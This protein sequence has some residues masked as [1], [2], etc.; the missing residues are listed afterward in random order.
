[1]ELVNVGIGLIF[2]MTLAFLLLVFILRKFAWKP[3][4]GA[5][6]EREDSIESALH[7]AD[8]AREEMAQLQA[9]N[10]QLLREA[11]EER[12]AMLKETRQLRDNIIEEAKQKANAEYNRILDSARENIQFEKMAAITELK[13]EVASLSLQF[14]EKLLREELSDKVKHEE[15]IRKHINEIKFN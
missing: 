2:W 5:L 1:M 13:N 3:I 8:K 11:R 6:K 14:A 12:D 4:M 10:E 7:M 9:N 15:Y